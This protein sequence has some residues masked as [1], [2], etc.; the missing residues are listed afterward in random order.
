MDKMQQLESLVENYAKKCLAYYLTFEMGERRLPQEV[1]LKIRKQYGSEKFLPVID[2]KAYFDPAFID[3][4]ALDDLISA[5]LK[6]KGYDKESF[7]L[8]K[9]RLKNFIWNSSREK[10]SGILERETAA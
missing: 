9:D 1:R 3:S 4:D 5:Y 6:G 10:G 2:W 7:V 8:P